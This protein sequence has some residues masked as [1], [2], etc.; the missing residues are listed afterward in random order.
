M[1]YGNYFWANILFL[2][3]AASHMSRMP[4]F[5]SNLEEEP[6]DVRQAFCKYLGNVVKTMSESR[7]QE[8]MSI[9]T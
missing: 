9:I 8:E 6:E 7:E 1:S 4:L 3:D 2:S 5:H